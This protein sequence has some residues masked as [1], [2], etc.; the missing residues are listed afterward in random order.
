MYQILKLAT[1]LQVFAYLTSCTGDSEGFSVLEEQNILSK[2]DSDAA[3]VLT[4]VQDET[5]FEGSLFEVD[6]NNEVDGTD[7]DT[8]FTCEFDTVAD[9][10]VK[11]GKSCETLPGEPAEK[12]NSETGLFLWQPS[13][14]SSG[15]YELS[16]TGTSNQGV[17]VEV[18]VLTVTPDSRPRLKSILDQ[19]ISYSEQLLLD[20]NDENSG[21]DVGMT[22]ECTFDNVVD[23]EASGGTSCN[24]LPGQPTIKFNPTSGQL[25]WTP[26]SEDGGSYEFE[27]TATKDGYSDSEVFVI[28]VSESTDGA[29][30]QIGNSSIDFDPVSWDY[31]NV[32]VFTESTTKQFTLTNNAS[33]DVFIGE[34]ENTSSHFELLF[35]TCTSNN[36]LEPG[37]DCTIGLRFT[38][39]TVTQLGTSIT[40]KFGRDSTN[41]TEFSSVLGVSGNAFGDLDFEGL[42]NISNITHNSLRLNWASTPDA[43]S[44]IIFE[45]DGSSLNYVETLV[46][47]GGAVTSTTIIGLQPSSSYTYRVRAN[48]VVGTTDSNTKNE[49]ATT[50]DNTSPSLDTI[51]DPAVYSGVLISSINAN[52]ENTGSD[53][54]DDG[55]AIKYTCKFDNSIN[56]A[57]DDLSA[58]DC[59]TISSEGGGTASFSATTGIFSGWTPQHADVDTDYEFKITGTDTYG[60]SSFVVFSTSVQAGLPLITSVSDRIFPGDYVRVG[61][62]IY[63]DFDNVRFAPATDSGITYA[64][65]YRV[66][67]SFSG[68]PNTN[69]SSLPGTISFDTSTG[70][71][72]W[73]VTTASVGAYEFQF[74]GTNAAGTH[75]RTVTWNVTSLWEET[76]LILNLDAEFTDLEK[77]GFNVPNYTSTWTNLLDDGFDGV[78]TNFNTSAAW[79]GNGQPDNPFSLV[80]DGTNDF[81]LFG[82]D[83]NSETTLTFTTWVRPTGLATGQILFS[84]GDSGYMGLQLMTSPDGGGNVEFLVGE[85]LANYDS[86]VLA[87]SPVLYWRLGESAGSTAVDNSGNSYDGTYSGS[88]SLNQTGA[89]V[90]SID[91]AVDFDGGTAS[92]TQAGLLGATFTVEVWATWE[93]TDDQMLFTAGSNGGG[94]ALHFSGGNIYWSTWDGAGNPICTIPAD[95]DDG[96]F[97]HYVMVNESG[98]TK[99]FYDGAECGT[100]NYRSSSSATL[101]HLGSGDTS[102]NGWAG[103]IDEVAVYNSALSESRIEVHYDAGSSS[104]CQTELVDDYWYHL[105]GY[106]NDSTKQLA[107][108]KN[109]SVA[110]TRSYPGVTI[111]GSS[112]D[113]SLGADDDGSGAWPGQMAA[114]RFYNSGGETEI[115]GNYSATKDQFE[116]RFLFPAAGSLEFWLDS[117]VSSSLFQ[118]NTCTTAATS[119][120]DPVG[121]WQDQSG[122][123]NHF[124]SDANPASLAAIGV[125]FDGT[126]D[127]LQNTGLNFDAESNKSF[128]VVAEPDTQTDGGSCCRPVLSFTT[129]SGGLYPWIGFQRST[130]DAFFG[131]IGSAIGSTTVPASEVML[132]SATHNGSSKEW[133]AW[134]NGTQ[135]SSAQTIPAS[136]SGATS[137]FVGGDKNSGT[138]RF[139]G[140]LYEVLGFSRVLTPTEVVQVEGYLACKWDFRS[141]LDSDHT[142]YNAS[143][144]SNAGCP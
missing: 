43:I 18:F 133:N 73:T 40:A 124:V 141:Q 26:S 46:N 25:E 128:F 78:L 55:D 70:I 143:D 83:I 33:A 89:I 123:S 79:T 41:T 20:F 5:V 122:N 86:V 84:Y 111:N 39:K 107:L 1:A 72:N 32:E 67:T 15:V 21:T 99:L 92:V 85:Q 134:G 17:D 61:D 82:Q 49:T 56:G 121:C 91:T 71:F 130:R 34:I 88:Y 126:A 110:C 64:C 93:G 98:N 30:G 42:D 113:F 137:L 24:S 58:A 131:W 81:V 94:P 52:D 62:N 87:D 109:G 3:I 96:S 13:T 2:G 22:Y 68:T 114:L 138:R 69:C 28:T 77:P 14:D 103:I 7:D 75:S 57:V 9:D 135:K 38:P 127:V 97:H 129:T 60:D 104:R 80:F 8:T 45:V 136:Y 95:A 65:V 16:I 4:T 6:I 63:I 112:S 115:Q 59:S 50:L 44:F 53:V 125:D 27:V 118:T 23:G 139:N 132:F 35:E 105:G 108:Y 101:F 12:F 47:T 48:D 37:D 76:D 140:R 66:I 90:T 100:T 51:A 102:S 74:S 144:S 11:D 106:F 36:P 19:N 119:L 54:D 120:S 29:F 116:N 31:G 117:S 142:Y 10:V